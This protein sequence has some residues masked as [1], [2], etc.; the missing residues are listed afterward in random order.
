MN[1]VAVITGAN[2]GIGFA[3]ARDLADRGLVVIMTCRDEM[4]GKKALKELENDNR[5]ISFYPMDVTN[6]ESIYMLENFLRTQYAVLDVLI[7]NA[8]IISSST[9]IS[10]SEIEEIRS[11]MGTNF[12]GPLEVTRALLPLLQKSPDARIINISSGMGARE[13]LDGSYAGYRLSKAGLNNFTQMLARD[14][15]GSPVK[16][17]SMCPGW[18]KTDMGGSAAPR[19]VEEGADTAVWLATE[20]PAPES[21][22]FYRDRKIISY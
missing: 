7:N 11:V 15:D 6:V 19:T 22:K 3:I 21:G 14:L 2:R 20:T 8:G 10:V 1:R 16:V 9:S 13:E 17:Y 4:K 12:F 18:V 5:K